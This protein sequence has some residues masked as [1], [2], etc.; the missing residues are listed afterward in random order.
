MCLLTLFAI[1]VCVFAMINFYKLFLRN[2]IYR[3]ATALRP[4]K[5][6]LTFL[7]SS[8]TTLLANSLQDALASATL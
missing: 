6:L 2:G 4:S 7:A 1:S 3:S 5:L 8:L